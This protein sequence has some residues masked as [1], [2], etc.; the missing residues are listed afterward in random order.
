LGPIPNPQI[1]CINK[2]FIF[3]NRIEFLNNNFF[4]YFNKIKKISNNIFELK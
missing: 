1:F 2:I 3:F 4:F